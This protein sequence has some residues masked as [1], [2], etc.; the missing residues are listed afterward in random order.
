MNYI[1]IKHILI[2]TVVLHCGP[3]SRSANDQE[4]FDVLNGQTD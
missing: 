1:Q 3:L 2:V 4:P